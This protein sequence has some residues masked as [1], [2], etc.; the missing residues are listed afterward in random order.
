[1]Y[2]SSHPSYD[3]D[4]GV[5]FPYVVL[6]GI[7]RG[8]VFGVFMLGAWSRNLSRQYVD[9]M[10]W[11]VYIGEEIIG[12]CL[13]FGALTMHRMSC[14]SFSWHWHGVGAQVHLSS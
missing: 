9:S 11:I 5:Y 14:L 1:V 12:V 7:N 2:G 6:H 8:V 10:N 3:G 13:W 4:E